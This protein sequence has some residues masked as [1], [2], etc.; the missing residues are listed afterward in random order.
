MA[1]R[2]PKTVSVDPPRDGQRP[3][4]GRFVPP[5]RQQVPPEE[6]T[7]TAPKT[8]QGPG[9]LRRAAGAVGRAAA[10]SARALGRAAGA[11]G[12]FFS[13]HARVTIL[14]AAAVLMV[15]LAVWAVLGIRDTLKAR[16][17]RR[18]AMRQSAPAVKVDLLLPPPAMYAD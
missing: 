9:P 3:R 5:S 17:D 15:L 14:S 7:E 11:T 4:T 13:R 6:P 10:S 12:A 8:P 18:I 1:P 2:R 16:H